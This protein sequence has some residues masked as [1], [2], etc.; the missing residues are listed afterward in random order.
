MQFTLA[1][2]NINSV[3]LRMPL[4][5]RF[6]Q[7]SQPDVLCLQETKVDDPLFPSLE[8]QA[9]GYPYIAFSGEK[10]YN[11]VAILSKFPLSDVEVLD[12]TRSGQKRHI[13]ASLPD[14]TR[15]HNIYIPAGGD[16]PDA[17]A[18]PKFAMKL[19]MLDHLRDWS[20]SL[21][22][23]PRIMVGDYNVAPL[24]HDVYNHKQMLKIVSHTPVEI[25]K[26][27]AMQQAGRW[28]DAVRTFIPEDQK[29]YSWWSYRA[30]DW[31][32]S[33]RGRKLDHIWLSQSLVP[34]LQ[35]AS[36]LKD[37][38]GWEQ[39]SDHVPVIASFKAI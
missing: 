18:N 36:M 8:L 17:M 16:L 4:V 3:R 26:M 14:G 7:H 30:A 32:A 29:A 20:L 11:G 2:W 35:A 1:T 22:D 5:R 39:P 37:A 27:T 15:I 28:V 34:R 38:R 25:E 6:V 19:G 21:D 23:Q 10:S 13:A 31:L 33:D 24:E 9:L 12:F